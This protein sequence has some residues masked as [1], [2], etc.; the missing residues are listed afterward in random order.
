MFV[1]K[2]GTSI[3]IYVRLV[4]RIH[5]RIHAHKLWHSVRRV[6]RETKAAGHGIPRYS[7][8]TIS[9]RC[10]HDTRYVHAF[11]HAKAIFRSNMIIKSNGIRNSSG[12]QILH[13][14]IPLSPAAFYFLLSLPSSYSQCLPCRLLRSTHVFPGIRQGMHFSLPLSF[15]FSPPSSFLSLSERTDTGIHEAGGNRE[16]K[17]KHRG[18]SDGKRRNV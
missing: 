10:R 8:I 5:A 15:F 6:A 13:R 2:N 17:R 7:R 1:E 9:R 3:E 14:P 12:A 4:F 18:K 16:T 11:H